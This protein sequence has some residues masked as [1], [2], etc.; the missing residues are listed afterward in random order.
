MAERLDAETAELLNYV[1]MQKIDVD[2]DPWRVG[3]PDAD[4]PDV[5]IHY[6]SRKSDDDNVISL[7]GTL[8]GI[9][10]DNYWDEVTL[11][12]DPNQRKTDYYFS[13]RADKG[14]GS[15]VTVKS[16]RYDRVDETLGYLTSFEIVEAPDPVAADDAEVSEA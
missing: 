3:D 12:V 5:R 11:Y 14:S 13:Y 16:R 1:V 4:N 7:R 9:G 10:V 8:T 6:Q 15:K 2:G